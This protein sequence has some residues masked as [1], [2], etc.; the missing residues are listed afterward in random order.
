[1]KLCFIILNYCTFEETIKCITSINED[2]DV[3]RNDY[4]IIV[5]DNASSDDSYQKL[6][7][8]YAN[9]ENVV[10]IANN[11]N[12]GFAKGNNIGYRYAKK[13]YNPNYIVMTNSD[14]FIIQK[15]FYFQL[16]K[17]FKC[18]KYAVLGPKI[19]LANNK[20]NIFKDKIETSKQIKTYILKLK[21]FLILSYLNLYKIIDIIKKI[22]FAK[23][24]EKSLNFEKKY[25]V[26]LHGCCWIF[27]QEYISRFDGIDEKTFLYNE[28]DFLYLKVMNSNL[29]TVYCP[30]VLIFHDCNKSTK[31]VTKTERKRRIFIYRNLIKSNKIFY[32]ELKKYE[33]RRN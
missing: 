3:N 1:M 19:I 12:Q 26:P 18:S 14:T 10:I 20:V 21:L 5:V 22:K 23:R 32:E 15:D 24:E 30:N 6:K 27:S 4:K 28:E 13:E 2:I 25:N 29:K 11:E 33:N 16:E 31:K 8:K 7:D 17:E 9:D